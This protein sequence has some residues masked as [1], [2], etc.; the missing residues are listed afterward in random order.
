V[1]GLKV[2]KVPGKNRERKVFLYTLSTC[3]WCKRTKGFL[4]DNGIEHDYV[5]IDLCNDEEREEAREHILKLGGS[6]SYPAIIID[7]K[8]LI[9]GYR[10]DK[11]KEV[12]KIGHD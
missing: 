11:L 3:V 9:N 6:L 4:K 1:Q 2:V 12:L 7:D 5:D 8:I 10:E